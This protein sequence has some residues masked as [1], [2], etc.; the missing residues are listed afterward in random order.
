MV[1]SFKQFDSFL[2]ESWICY[3]RKTADR[4]SELLLFIK[5]YITII[6]VITI[7][8]KGLIVMQLN[9]GTNDYSIDF[10]TEFDRGC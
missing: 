1:V 9:L 7:D 5:L 10:G 3:K 6:L 2:S 4:S 8:N